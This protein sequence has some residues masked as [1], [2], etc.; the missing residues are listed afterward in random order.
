MAT[1]STR[2][3]KRSTINLSNPVG[4][5]A[6]T[7]PGVGTILNDDAAPTVTIITPASPTSEGNT[8]VFSVSL[9][10]PSGK[11]VTVSYT[12]ASQA[13]D[14]ATAGADYTPISGTL[15][16]TPGQTSQAISVVI[17][18]DEILEPNETFHVLLS[19]ANNATLGSSA[20]AVGTHP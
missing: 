11:T 18:Q 15:T 8:A 14:T 10:Q 5:F 9:S 2:T 16:F 17:L 6:S 19:G 3:T 13:G 20:T 1:R 4:A 12:T 7:S